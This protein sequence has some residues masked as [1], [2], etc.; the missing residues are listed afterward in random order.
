[1]FASNKDR[2]R[3]GEPL[4]TNFRL[5]SS[6]G[7][8]ALVKP[9]G[10]TVAHQYAPYPVQTDD[11][12]YGLTLVTTQATL[13][14]T[15]AAARVLVPTDDSLGLGWT[16]PDFDDAA[17][18]AATTGVGYET[19]GSVTV[20]VA[21]SAAE[22]S[23]VQGQDNWF[24]GYYNLTR[25]TVAGYQASNFVAFPSGEA[26]FSGLN[27][28]TGTAWDWFAGN[29]PWDEIG[30]TFMHPNGRNNNEEHWVI[31][32]WVSEVAGSITVDWTLAKANPAGNG[33][34]GIILHNGAERDKFSIAG[35]NTTGVSRSITIHNVQIGDFIDVALTPVGPPPG[36]DTGDG[37]DGSTMTAVIKTAVSLA[38]LISTDIEGP[39]R[40]NNASAYVRVPF[41]VTDPTSYD[42]L[43]V[44][45]KYDD[46]AV[47]YLN[48]TEL[49]SRNATPFPQWNA[50]ATGTR[51][52]TLAGQFEEVDVS[53][54]LVSLRPGWNVLAIHGLNAAADDADFLVLPEVRASR[55]SI[56]TA[57]PRYLPGPTPG[58]ANGEGA[59]TLG[60]LITDVRHTPK[61]PNDDQDLVVTARAEQ[62]FRPVTRMELVYRVMFN[63]EVTVQMFDDGQHGDGPAG[64]GQFGA[65]IPAAAS[66][67]GQMVRYFIRAT[68]SSNVVSR[69][70][71]YQNTN[72][73]PQYFGT[74]V[75][76]PSLVN[77]LPVVHLFIPQTTLNNV[78]ND[79][80]GRYPASI[81]FLGE[82]Y[83]N[84]GINRHGQSSAGGDF[85]RKSY[86]LD[87]NPGNLFKWKEGE[88]R[89]DDINLLTT[90]PDKAKMRN[91]LA[92]GTYRD[93][94]APYHF[95][96][97]V[98]VQH[99]A[100]YFGDWHMVE[101][102]DENFLKRLGFDPRGALYKMYNDFN[103]AADTTIGVNGEFAE[104][105]TRKHE[106][107]ADLL[108]LFNGVNAPGAARTAFIYD[109][110]NIPEVVN[111]L[112]ARVVTADI[113]CCHKN[114]YLYR[115]S[116]GTGEWY[117]MP[118]DVDLSFGRNWTECSNYWGDGMH[119]ENGL[120]TGNNNSF[121]NAIFNTPA[122]LQMYQRRVRTLINE[123]L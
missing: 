31:R 114:Y 108:A 67:N 78:H 30:A 106:G 23:G 34:T 20:V 46:G 116:E 70:P 99:N 1:M 105:K 27:F 8:L 80:L 5:S 83:D 32:R 59:A 91:M 96:E 58:A 122:L 113:D 123:L 47:V 6:P 4:H 111:F 44:R 25:D 37:S 10:V 29:P 22:F 94:D 117:A 112:A 69:L 21:D 9:D 115:D 79:S 60:P 71:S 61:Q 95:V 89:V 55:L 109:N 62:T 54:A 35:A 76:D 24:Y 75:K 28:W 56:D 40:G 19:E 88:D 68:D 33:V 45:M 90:Y 2:R 16:Q 36:N 57:T 81:Y 82:F 86:D 107:S 101:N 3:P 38:P 77:P 42:F 52:E 73:S 39:M 104:K 13:L 102:G 98:R 92:Y 100:V 64:D 50:A 103:Q 121:F 84:I 118:W 18:T 49:F 74:V 66:T 87:F 120:R 93:A 51:D 12:A 119:P 43:T 65:T 53:R 41:T 85:L 14:S 26:P 97:P 7:Y 15:G 72:N 63:P 48:G 17:W 110:L 11:I